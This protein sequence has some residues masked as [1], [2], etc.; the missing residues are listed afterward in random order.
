MNNRLVLIPVIL[1]ALA[2][3]GCGAASAAG[4]GSSPNAPTLSH[5]SGSHDVV[6]RVST[7]GGFVSP[8]YA[9]TTLP[10]FTL[11]G[12]GTVIVPGAVTEIYPGPAIFPLFSFKLSDSRMQALLESAKRAGL[13]ADGRIDYGDMGSVGIT[14]NPTTTVTL[15]VDGRQL[16]RAAYALSARATGGR[17]TRDQ[18][19]AR[20]ALLRFIQSLPQGSS[21][22]PYTPSA[23]A[24]NIAPFSGE[25][26]RG[27]APV[28]WPLASNLATVGKPVSAGLPYRCVAVAGDDAHLLLAALRTANDQT[29]WIARPSSNRTFQ[30]VVRPLLPDETGCST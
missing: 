25:P 29:Q 24:V 22:R 2:A 12:D 15:N 4:D 6:L 14:D 20:R 28:V 19:H 3:T 7:G 13:L 26:Q 10:E 8:Q 30:L 21:A 27:A 23:I 5:P 17:L 11:Y 1:T 18:S 9:M 16:T